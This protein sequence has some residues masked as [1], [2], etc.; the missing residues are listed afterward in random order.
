MNNLFLAVLNMSLIGAIVIA[1]IFA[2]RFL[3]KRFPT[4]I[5][6]CLWAVAGVRLLLP[7][8]FES[9]MGLIPFGGRPVDLVVA[10]VVNGDYSLTPYLSSGA[11]TPHDV[12]FVINQMDYASAGSSGVN[13]LAV[14][15][16]AWFVVAAAMIFYGV[17]SY[18][19]L[20]RKLRYASWRTQNI[21]EADNIRSPFVLGILRP[22]V[23]LP[24]GLSGQEREYIILHELTH[25]KRKDHIVQII[26]YLVL[27]LH[28]F[29]PLV[30]AALRYMKA[31]ME[32]SCDEVVLEKM[33]GNIKKS[34]SMSLVTLAEGR[35]FVNA[36]PLAFGEG[37]I[38]KRVNNVL[39]FKR[40][41]KG[42]MAV[43]A[44]CAVVLSGAL[45]MNAAGD[46]EDY[47]NLSPRPGQEHQTWG[48]TTRPERVRA[49]NMREAG[50]T[51]IAPELPELNPNDRRHYHMRTD[52][53]WGRQSMM[54]LDITNYNFQSENARRIVE[55]F[56]AQSF[57]TWD[58]S[59]FEI[60]TSTYI[61]NAP[62]ADMAMPHFTVISFDGSKFYM[63]D[64]TMP[65][66]HEQG[67]P[68]R[69][70]IFDMDGSGIPEVAIQYVNYAD[71]EFI[72]H[73]VIYTF[74]DGLFQP[75]VSHLFDFTADTDVPPIAQYGEITYIFPA[76]TNMSTSFEDGRLIMFVL[77]ETRDIQGDRFV[78]LVDG[79]LIIE[80]Q[81]FF[82]ISV[83]R[84]SEGHG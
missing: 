12:R 29:N 33:G 82:P 24:F 52:G 40:T 4:I 30:W 32:M 27:C 50:E 18:I 45:L 16:S 20:K 44:L 77:C 53:G 5:S 69:H 83:I 72:R 51:R 67:T 54:E 58:T 21:F 9:V 28:W 38:R 26:G 22:R 13:W 7:L 55:N 61:T 84:A 81:L 68:F 56:L 11:I 57:P 49:D 19:M 65:A 37:N 64:G 10:P 63:P 78:K 15:A 59:H 73:S 1:A 39:K 23:Y 80:E 43:A 75:I 62:T 31:D 66:T 76:N 6:Y 2:A 70:Y 46:T 25:I 17:V 71:G 74:Q 60:N 41:S 35:H 3:L 48:D 14:L 47:R 79:E 36:C 34:Y 42:I 8:T